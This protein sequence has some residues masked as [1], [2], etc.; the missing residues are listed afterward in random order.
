MADRY[1]VWHIANP[2]VPLP[3]FYIDQDSEPS[4]LRVYAA[5]TPNGG[6]LLVDILDDGVSIMNDNNSQ[7]TSFKSEDAYIE[8]G[9]PTLTFT[10]NET[11]TGGTSGAT[12]KVSKNQ[13]G[14]VTLFD[15]SGIF[16][17]G[18]TITGGSSAATGVIGSYVRQVKSA[19]RTIVTGKSH[20]NLSKNLTS[21]DSAQD[22]IPGVQIREGSWVSLNPLELNGASQVTIQLELTAL[23][24]SLDGKL[25]RAGKFV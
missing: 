13:F 2:G 10:V 20:A 21:T 5:T 12:A 15:V 14:R 8:F 4:A 1:L 23:G 9:A 25:A 19:S 17:S 16:T 6:D 22:F 3:V 24:E 7:K 11:I 18:E